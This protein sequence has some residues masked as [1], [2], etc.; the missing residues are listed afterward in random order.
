MIR[1]CI[2]PVL[3]GLEA[4]SLLLAMSACRAQPPDGVFACTV[5]AE[6]PT[7]LQ[8]AGGLCRRH[9]LEDDVDPSTT[10]RDAGADASADAVSGAGGKRAASGGG[11]GGKPAADGGVE[12]GG[13]KPSMPTEPEPTQPTL[14][15]TKPF[16]PHTFVPLPAGRS[17]VAGGNFARSASY[18]LVHTLGQSPA[19]GYP[20][21][22]SAKY[23]M[24]GGAIGV[25]QT[26]K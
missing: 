4:L 15:P 21:R 18:Q 10:P 26:E 12:V 20:V 17:V 19:T 13:E 11:S 5:T 25:V 3:R 22:S 23:R 1:T 7:G 24:I 9:A 16:E 8:C 2:P 14:P 6:C